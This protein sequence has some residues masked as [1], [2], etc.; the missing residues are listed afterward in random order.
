MP[1][2]IQKCKQNIKEGWL[3]VLIVPRLSVDRAKGMAQGE[4]IERQLAIFSMEDFIAHNIVEM[5]NE[6][7]LGLIDTLREIVKVYNSRIEEAEVDM[8]LRIEIR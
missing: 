7:N 6:K 4:G 1:S 2:V 8:S 3:P 5:A